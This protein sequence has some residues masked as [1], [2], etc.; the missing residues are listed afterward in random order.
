MDSTR[1]FWFWG[2]CQLRP[3]PVLGCCG[4]NTHRTQGS[5]VL[6]K[7]CVGFS[8]Q[9]HTGWVQCQLYPAP[10]FGVAAITTM[11]TGCLC[12]WQRFVEYMGCRS[13]R[14]RSGGLCEV[15][16]R[17]AYRSWVQCQLWR[18]PFLVLCRMHSLSASCPHDASDT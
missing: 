12:V 11:D 6:A 8:Q 4:N 2:Q 10:V 3:A 18:A 7:V 1:A 9:M 16:S 17:D 15:G 5:S 13:W 14:L